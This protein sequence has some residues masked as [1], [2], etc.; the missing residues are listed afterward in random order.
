LKAGTQTDICRPIYIAA[1]VTKAK[2]WKQLKHPLTDEWLHKIQCLYTMEHYSALK[3]NKILTYATIWMNL[4]DIML[5][6]ISR[7]KRTNMI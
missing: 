3:R 6:E 7:Y 1:L 4:E 2:R 5:S